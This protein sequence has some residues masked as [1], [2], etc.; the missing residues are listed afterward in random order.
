MTDVTSRGAIIFASGMEEKTISRQF[1][2]DEEG[3]LLEYVLDSVWTV[4]DEIVVVF[5]K[6][7]KLSIVESIS[8][9]GAKVIT[10]NQNQGPTFSILEAF[11]TSKAE[12]CLLTTERVPLLKPNVILSLFENA[13]GHDLAIPRWN[14]G[15]LAP[16]L[17]V[18]RK[19]ALLKLVSTLNLSNGKDLKRDLGKIIE[20]LFAVKYV[21]VEKDLKEIDPEL[22][23]FLEI[24]GDRSLSLA[25]EKASIKGKKLQKQAK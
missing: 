8:P 11:R 18:Y 16:M 23:S 20:Q 5:G 19:N 22:D 4:A 13:L 6:E 10:V 12:H 1:S 14:D 3:S 25:R 7:P 24:D 15:K 2:P 21:S 17:A 9:F